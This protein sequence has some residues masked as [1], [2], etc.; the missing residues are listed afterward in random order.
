M[1]GNDFPAAIK[2][3]ADRDAVL[4]DL[5]EHFQA[6]RLTAA[7]LKGR[8]GRHWPHGPGAS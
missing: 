7:E 8:R 5:N 2:P 3:P 1:T 4:S 6:G